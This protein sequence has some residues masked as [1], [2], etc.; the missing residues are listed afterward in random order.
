MAKTLYGLVNKA[1]SAQGMHT[2]R[3]QQ[4][5]KH[6][7][8]CLSHGQ[9]PR[10]LP[11]ST[12]YILESIQRTFRTRPLLHGS[13]STFYSCTRQSHPFTSWFRLE[14]HVIRGESQAE[15]ISC[16][17]RSLDEHTRFS[18][19]PPK[20][21]PCPALQVS[22]RRLLTKVRRISWVRTVSTLRCC[23]RAYST[24]FGPIAKTVEC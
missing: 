15:H 2:R 9:T 13:L 22:Q 14:S 10:T 4:I 3:T 7:K 5:W 8:F 24:T 11:S 19:R 23:S 1:N 18:S 6:E 17:T 16:R 12:G 20:S 21:V